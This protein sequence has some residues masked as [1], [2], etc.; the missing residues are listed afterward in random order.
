LCISLIKKLPS[1]NYSGF[2]SPM[3]RLAT[4]FH[5]KNLL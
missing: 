3:S 2:G 4:N 5:K 1:K